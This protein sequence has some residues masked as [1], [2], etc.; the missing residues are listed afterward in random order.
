MHSSRNV[1][2]A[3]AKAGYC[4]GRDAP[5]AAGENPSMFMIINAPGL[6]CEK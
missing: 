1:N 6:I 3:D 2:V 5:P 4:G